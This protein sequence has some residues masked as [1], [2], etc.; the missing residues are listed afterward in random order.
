MTHKKE[1]RRM[2]HKKVER[3][4]KHRKEDRINEV[5]LISEYIL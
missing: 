1:E 3:K 4:M 5:G 2:K